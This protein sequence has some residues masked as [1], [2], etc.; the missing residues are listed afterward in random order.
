MKE[1]DEGKEVRRSTHLYARMFRPQKFNDIIGA[2]AF[3]GDSGSTAAEPSQQNESSA[4]EKKLSNEG[5]SRGEGG[6]G[7]ERVQCR[8]PHEQQLKFVPPLYRYLPRCQD[9]WRGCFIWLSCLLPVEEM[10][11]SVLHSTRVGFPRQR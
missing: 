4:T 5:G 1:C 9:T 6:R 10:T 7:T 2:R 8:W 11:S 3:W